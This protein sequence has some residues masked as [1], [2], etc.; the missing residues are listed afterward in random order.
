MRRSGAWQSGATLLYR[1]ATQVPLRSVSQDEFWVVSGGEAQEMKAQIEEHLG[2][3]TGE[4]GSQQ[5]KKEATV[6]ENGYHRIPIKEVDKES[7]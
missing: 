1:M 7:F 3:V 6:K 5:S 4:N 2:P